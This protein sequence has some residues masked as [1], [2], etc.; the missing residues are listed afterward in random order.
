MPGVIIPDAQG[1]ARN[2]KVAA[3]SDAVLR[4]AQ[5]VIISHQVYGQIY[6]ICID[7]CSIIFK[8]IRPGNLGPAEREGAL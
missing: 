7:I 5:A 4:T 3:Y 8:S 1:A 2:G 6:C